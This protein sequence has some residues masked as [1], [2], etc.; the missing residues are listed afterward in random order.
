MLRDDINA[1][2][3]EAM[4]AHDSR[5]VSTLRLVN[6]ALKNA[7]IEARGQGKAAL[8]DEDVLALLQK[9]VKQRQESVDLYEKG[10]RPELAAQERE[11]IEVISAYLPKQLSPEETEAA[12]KA[13]IAET[14]ASGM[15]D[16]GKV[17]AVLRE[18]HA[19]QLDMGKASGLVK[20]LLK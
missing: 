13:V 8:T 18:R 12:V 6:A 14:G 16:M 1:A 5:R 2:L 10:G 9:M 3:K 17:I 19:G 7:D 15:K 20:G 4:K 11:E